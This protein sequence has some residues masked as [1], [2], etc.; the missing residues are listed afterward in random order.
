MTDTA[1]EY[2]SIFK[3][4]RE[5]PPT[6]NRLLEEDERVRV[7]LDKDLL[8]KRK[9]G[10]KTGIIG[11][12]VAE[13]SAGGKIFRIIDT[14]KSDPKNGFYIIDDTYSRGDMRGH[15]GV[16]MSG[17]VT[18]GR[19]HHADRFDY[20]M[21]VSGEHFKVEY[22]RRVA[23]GEEVLYVSNMKPRN[24]TYVTAH[25]ANG[26]DVPQSIPSRLFRIDDTR[27]ET[28]EDRIQLNANY[29]QK[30]ETAPYGY[31]MNY[32]ILGRRSQVVDGGVY[33]GGSS[34]EAIVV[35]GKSE[36]LKNVYKT[37]L[38]ELQS[39][40]RR[41]E[42]LVPQ[43]VLIKVMFAVQQSMPY[44]G[45]K[46]EG[47]S[48]EHYG[49]KLIGLSTYVKEKA[50]VCRHQGLLAAYLIEGLIQDGYLA[51]SVGVE[52]NTVEDLGGTHAWAIFKPKTE[53]ART[54]IV[55]DPAQSFVGTKMQAEQE[56]RWAYRLSTDD[57]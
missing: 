49:D 50:G 55:V 9:T 19:R 29:G 38:Q 33:L 42:T 8:N 37:L 56:Q 27:T 30:D 4:K 18:I 31:Y 26:D 25:L 1:V 48:L 43:Q 21:T 3:I 20:P 39:S 16:D 40:F 23:D 54:A 45:P 17:P 46:T 2:A 6:T 7:N 52:R 32:P 28:A 35:D 22:T 34:R 24:P 36:I 57:Y 15:V 47:I 13:I 44:D 14:R 51:G 5:V 41:S 53:I 12:L 10:K 11:R